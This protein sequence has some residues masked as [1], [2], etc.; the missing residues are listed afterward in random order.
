MKDN[1][2]FNLYAAIGSAF[3]DG[4]SLTLLISSAINPR[5]KLE[6]ILIFGGLTVINTVSAI[7]NL[8]IYNHDKDLYKYTKN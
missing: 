4:I 7:N 5:G 3:A 2:K 1:P 6:D 8:L